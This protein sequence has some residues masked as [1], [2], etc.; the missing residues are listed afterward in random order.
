MVTRLLV[1]PHG[2]MYA[3]ML[4]A[5]LGIYVAKFSRT[6]DNVTREEEYT[7]MLL[8]SDLSLLHFSRTLEPHYSSKPHITKSAKKVL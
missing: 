6:H 8:E 7:S 3:N 2:V 5:L 1:I 4:A